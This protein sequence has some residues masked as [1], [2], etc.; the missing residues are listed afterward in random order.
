[1]L[2]AA[3]DTDSYMSNY[4][5]NKSDLSTSFALHQRSN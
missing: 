4:A 5:P 1:L 2:F 3:E